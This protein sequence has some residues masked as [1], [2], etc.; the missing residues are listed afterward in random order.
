MHMLET[1]TGA[2]VPLK[3]PLRKMSFEQYVAL[4]G[5]NWSS[6]RHMMRSPAHFAAERVKRPPTDTDDFRLG[7]AVHAAVLEPET[8][9]SDF[10]T[11]TGER[12][13]GNEWKAFSA[14]HVGRTV[15]TMQ[16]T[17]TANVLAQSVRSSKAAMRYLASGAAELSMEWNSGVACKG[18]IDWLS[19]SSPAIVDVKTTKDASPESFFASAWRLGY[20]G[21]FA[22]YVDGYERVTGQR[23]PFV[24]IAVEKT[25]PYV[26]QVYRVSEAYLELGRELYASL[27]DR[28]RAC[29]RDGVWPGYSDEELDLCPP[30]WAR[31]S[32]DEDVE[33]DLDFGGGTTSSTSE[34]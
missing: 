3:N 14:S 10:I 23:L 27:L 22:W 18:R 9:D 16:Q 31:P 1:E 2:R 30:R 4:P 5:L 13:S 32:E 26:V 29:Q 6:L 24:V 12:R 33:G 34:E 28:L 7:R 17:L 11:W 20:H 21:Q 8:F 15:L 19:A 25:H